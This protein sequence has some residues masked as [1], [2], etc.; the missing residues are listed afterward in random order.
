MLNHNSFTGY[1]AFFSGKENGRIR[2]NQIVTAPTLDDTRKGIDERVN[3][4]L[5]SDVKDEDS[6]Y[7]EE[8]AIG[9][10]LWDL[11]NKL[12]VF[13]ELELFCD[14]IPSS[15]VKSYFESEIEN[16]AE[17]NFSKVSDY[18]GE[19]IFGLSDDEYSIIQKKIRR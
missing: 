11:Y 16:F 14:H 1:G 6:S 5:L 8:N 19:A 12:K 3:S 17:K 15:I 10:A 2:F 7:G 9:L 4:K 13:Y 18:N